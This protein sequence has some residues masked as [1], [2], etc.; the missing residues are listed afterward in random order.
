[1]SILQTKVSIFRPLHNP[2]RFE[3]MLCWPNWL[4]QKKNR[5][6]VD[7]KGT[8]RNL[9]YYSN[10]KEQQIIHSRQKIYS[11][12]RGTFLEVIRVFFAPEKIQRKND[13]YSLKLKI[14]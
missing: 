10:R 4:S 9:L 12:T 5:K 13:L 3:T 8:S 11:P 7:N 14:I 1:M 2:E 6:K